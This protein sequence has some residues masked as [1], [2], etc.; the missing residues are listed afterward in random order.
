VTTPST[1]M[2]RHPLHVSA[3]AI[4]GWAISDSDLPLSPHK[5]RELLA[6]DVEATGTTLPTETEC[7]EMICGLSDR[8]SRPC[9]DG[10]IPLDLIE[11]FPTTHAWLEEQWA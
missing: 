10:G 2:G 3:D 9:N 6:A 8:E 11:R 4:R 1:P 7:C 5:L